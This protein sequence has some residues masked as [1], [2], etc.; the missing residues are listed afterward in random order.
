MVSPGIDNFVAPGRFS[1]SK[2]NNPAVLV[3]KFVGYAGYMVGLAPGGCKT[4]KNQQVKK[5]PSS[6]YGH[7]QQLHR[8][9]PIKKK[10]NTGSVNGKC[11]V[12]EFFPV[13]KVKIYLI[14]ILP[15]GK[16]WYIHPPHHA[17]VHLKTTTL[18]HRAGPRG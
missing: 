3:D 6:Y 2:G 5:N 8:I 10:F 4:G 18:S 1:G 11:P 14:F 9:S 12:L 7:L 15:G 17:G 16:I 13:L